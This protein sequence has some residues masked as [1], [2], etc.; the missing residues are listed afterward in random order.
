[1]PMYW[2]SGDVGSATPVT[3]SV[4]VPLSQCDSWIVGA[5]VLTTAMQHTC[6]FALQMVLPALAIPMFVLAT[7]LT[8]TQA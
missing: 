4:S 2:S 3:S 1:M 7:L 6:S 5:V 8:F